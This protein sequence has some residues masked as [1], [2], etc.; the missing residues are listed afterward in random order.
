MYR[1]YVCKQFYI[2]LGM[3]QKLS[4]ICISEVIEGIGLNGGSKVHLGSMVLHCLLLKETEIHLNF[5]LDAIL[6]RFSIGNKIRNQMD[7]DM[8]Y[9]KL[10]QRW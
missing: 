1:E 5:K 6:F 3:R 9:K 7:T 4:F 8:T 2:I 10:C